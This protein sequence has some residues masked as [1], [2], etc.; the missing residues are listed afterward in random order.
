MYEFSD[1]LVLVSYIS[2]NKSRKNVTLVNNMY[3][4]KKMKYLVMQ[5]NLKSSRSITQQREK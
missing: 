4:D 5:R 1:N 2:Q 3:L